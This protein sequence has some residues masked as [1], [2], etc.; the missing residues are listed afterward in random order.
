MLLRNVV[1]TCFG[2]S[3]NSVGNAGREH[4][5]MQKCAIIRGFLA[6]ASLG[7]E[8]ICAKQALGCIL[9]WHHTQLLSAHLCSVYLYSY[10]PSRGP[11]GL[12]CKNNHTLVKY[13][14][15]KNDPNCREVA[16]QNKG[17]NFKFLQQQNNI[18]TLNNAQSGLSIGYARESKKWKY[19]LIF[20]GPE[21]DHWEC[22]SVTP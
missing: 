19:L 16:G 21:S 1:C 14:S 6:F 22:L 2:A 11:R 3:D 15:C 5:K 18:T 4:C 8:W 17:L 20:I 13:I 9:N 12:I 10:N 7:E